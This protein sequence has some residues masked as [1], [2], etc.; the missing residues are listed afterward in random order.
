MRQFLRS[1]SLS[2]KLKTTFSGQKLLRLRLFIGQTQRM[3]T[4]VSCNFASFHFQSRERHPKLIT[5]LSIWFEVRHDMESVSMN[6]NSTDCLV[7]MKYSPLPY[8]YS[9]QLINK[10]Q[11]Q[12][13]TRYSIQRISIWV[14]CWCICIFPF[15]AFSN[16]TF[17]SASNSIQ[18]DT[19][20]M[21]HCSINLNLLID[22]NGQNEW[23]VY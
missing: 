3:A 5:K 18:H 2:S 12:A 8:P 4:Q 6:S 1:D 7:K 15:F 11:A 19:S 17:P 9:H 20:K 14:W 10:A 13:L 16:I 22:S 23:L 21:F